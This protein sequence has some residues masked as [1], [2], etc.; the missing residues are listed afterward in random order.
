MAHGPRAPA[1]AGVARTGALV[2]TAGGR[3]L[4]KTAP[5]GVRALAGRGI[6][7]GSMVISFQE[8][9]S[10]AGS[11]PWLQ[12]QLTRHSRFRSL[13]DFAMRPRRGCS[14]QPCRGW[15]KHASAKSIP[16]TA[17]DPAPV[18]TP[19]VI[20]AS[21]R[22]SQDDAASLAQRFL[23]R[24][25]AAAEA[26]PAPVSKAIPRKLSG[27]LGPRRPQVTLQ[28]VRCCKRDVEVKNLV[29]PSLFRLPVQGHLSDPASATKLCP[30]RYSDPTAHLAWQMT[31]KLQ[32]KQE[33]DP[34]AL[35]LERQKV[36]HQMQ[37]AA[38]NVFGMVTTTWVV[39][40]LTLRVTLRSWSFWS[41]RALRNSKK[42]FLSRRT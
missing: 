35:V 36:V 13:V 7:L 40:L 10:P 11:Q 39:T 22:T 37:L 25:A 2:A 34:R 21:Q 15:N 23:M 30:Q 24:K 5:V 27:C 12:V 28:R 3:I 4:E 16:A 9:P 41:A 31:Q 6:I 1:R 18:L 42:P 26:R 29:A 14:P 8:I 19:V 33:R 38:V 32:K 20:V 17:S